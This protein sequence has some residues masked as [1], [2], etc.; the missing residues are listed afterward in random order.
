MYVY[1]YLHDSRHRMNQGRKGVVI[2]GG[3][4][5][6]RDRCL[7]RDG[8]LKLLSLNNYLFFS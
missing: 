4:V 8:P 7:E 1:T 6:K 2:R 5:R 3:T